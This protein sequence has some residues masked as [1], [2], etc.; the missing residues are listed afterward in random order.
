MPVSLRLEW[1]MLRRLQVWHADPV[2]MVELLN[3]LMEK[4]EWGVKLT[5]LKTECL[6]AIDL[7]PEERER[8]GF[9]RPCRALAKDQGE[10]CNHV[11]AALPQGDK[12]GVYPRQAFK[13][14]QEGV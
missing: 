12:H 14:L 8:Q 1:A 6:H 11:N 7:D 9:W 13:M 4:T 5:E 2:A 3:W 10:K